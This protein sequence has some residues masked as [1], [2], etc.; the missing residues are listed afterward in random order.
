[1]I[2][3]RESCRKSVAKGKGAIAEEPEAQGHLA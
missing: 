3:L 2:S 1:M